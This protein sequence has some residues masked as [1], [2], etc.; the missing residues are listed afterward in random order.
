M[1]VEILS[2]QPEAN[3]AFARAHDREALKSY[4]GFT[5]VWHEQRHDFSAVEDGA[6]LGVATIEIAASLATVKGVIVAP[7]ARRRGIGRALLAQASDVANYYNCHKMTAEAPHGSAAQAFLEAC[8]Y[9]VEAVLPQH[10][11]KL[12]MAIMRKFLL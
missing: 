11:F 7:E 5:V 9:H 12:D 6:T 2:V 1:P 4:Y 10:A 3:A 8:G